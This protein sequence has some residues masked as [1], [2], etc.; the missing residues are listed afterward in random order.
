MSG[1]LPIIKYQNL[2][3]ALMSLEDSEMT[4][5]WFESNDIKINAD[6]CHLLALGLNITTWTFGHEKIRES[7]EAKLF[8]M[9]KN[10]SLKSENYV[11]TL[12][13]KANRKSN[14]LFRNSLSLVS[15]TVTT[16]T[17]KSINCTNVL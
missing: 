11:S 7:A 14:T 13:F 17:I 16:S 3:N 6:E 5:C 15:F 8:G 12:S 2:E 10:N 9:A 1:I 4:I